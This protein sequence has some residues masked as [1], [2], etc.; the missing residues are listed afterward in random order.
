[1]NYYYE[2]PESTK[3]FGNNHN[4]YW[5]YPNCS[6]A[7]GGDMNHVIHSEC[8][9]ASTRAW[10]ENANGVTLIKEQRREVSTVISENSQ[11]F[12]FVK[13]RARNILD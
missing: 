11:E 1:M 10:V 13:L 8:I 12:M 2:I 5:V 3:V 7:Q 6:P 4:G 9:K